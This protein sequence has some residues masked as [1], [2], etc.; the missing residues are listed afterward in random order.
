MT[1]P[2]SASRAAHLGGM[3]GVAAAAFVVLGV[4][5]ASLQVLPAFGGFLMMVFGLGLALVGLV[6][7]IV[8]FVATAPGKG[9][10]GRGAA[11][12]GLALCAI[13]LVALAIPASKGRDVPRINDITTD[14]ADPPKFVAALDANAGRDMAYPGETFARQQQAAYP[15]VATLALHDD[16]AATYERVREALKAMPRI[17]IIGENRAEGRIEA[18]ET[19]SLFHFAD[20]LVVRIRPGADGGSR[21]DVRSKS[22]V[23]K[24]DLG[25]NANRIRTLFARLQTSHGNGG[26]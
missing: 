25:V 21:V 15:D 9:R 12:R 2:T 22:R 17:E 5:L 11:I 1:P 8:G 3:L 24:G 13:V 4:G 6:T 26:D 10:E 23:G 7:S 19:S 14:V 20:D 18:T 16:P